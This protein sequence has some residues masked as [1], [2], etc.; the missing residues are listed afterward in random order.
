MA[1]SGEFTVEDALNILESLTE[2]NGN[3][4]NEVKKDIL[5]A[6]SRIKHEF[7]YLGSC[8]QKNYWLEATP[9]QTHSLLLATSS[10]TGRLY[11]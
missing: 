3:L 4:R 2:L 1:S 8:K 6:A 10:I 7:V 11:I 5:T 9:T